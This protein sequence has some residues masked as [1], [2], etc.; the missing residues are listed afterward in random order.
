MEVKFLT[1]FRHLFGLIVILPYFNAISVDFYAVQCNL[2]IPNLA[3]SE[4]LLNPNKLFGPKVFYHL[5][6]IK[7]PCVFRI[8]YIP[9]SEHKIQSLEYIID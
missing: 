2:S 5:L 3:Y 8:L 9:N 4:I 1:R 7:L 6:H